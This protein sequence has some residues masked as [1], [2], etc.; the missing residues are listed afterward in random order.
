VIFLENSFS[1][2]HTQNAENVATHEPQSSFF[3]V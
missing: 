3:F 1:Y 2:K